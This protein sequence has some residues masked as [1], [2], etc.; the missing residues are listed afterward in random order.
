MY[1]PKVCISKADVMKLS[2]IEKQRPYRDGLETKQSD[3]SAAKSRQ[4]TSFDLQKRSP[5]RPSG[6]SSTRN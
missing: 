3:E 1:S 4:N 2:S 6:Q 5:F